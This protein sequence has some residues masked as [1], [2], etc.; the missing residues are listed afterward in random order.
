M[1]KVTEFYVDLDWKHQY[2][3]VYQL[4]WDG[5]VFYFIDN[6]EYFGRDGIYGF[7]DDAERFIFSPK[8]VHFWVRK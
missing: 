1:E 4:K 8:R 2:T 6:L 5:V 3:G 7:D